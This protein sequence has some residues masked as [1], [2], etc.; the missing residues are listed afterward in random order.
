MEYAH[1][2]GTDLGAVTI[3]GAITP[4]HHPEHAHNLDTDL[5]TGTITPVDGLE[6]APN[7]DAG[8]TRHLAE[9]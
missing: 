8:P 4:A 1:N 5:D 2:L 3:E 7:L 6:L 9:G